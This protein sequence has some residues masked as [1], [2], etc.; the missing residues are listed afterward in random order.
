M[1]G[2]WFKMQALHF[3]SMP[4]WLHCGVCESRG[5]EMVQQQAGFLDNNAAY[6]AL[7]RASVT[8]SNV[9]QTS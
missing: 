4:Q 2:S 9:T 3:P 1:K 8:R 7:E 6:R 5:L